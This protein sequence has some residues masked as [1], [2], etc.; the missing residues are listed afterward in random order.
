MSWTYQ[1]ADGAPA[2]KL[3]DLITVAVSEKSVMTSDGK[4]DRKKKGYGDLIC[5]TGSC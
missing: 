4:M 5:P 1:K 2:L 3:H